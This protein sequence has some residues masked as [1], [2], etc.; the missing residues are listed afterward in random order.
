MLDTIKGINYR[1]GDSEE[2]IQSLLLSAEKERQFY[3]GILGKAP[4]SLRAAQWL[5]GEPAKLEDLKGRPVILHFWN[6]WCGPC[7][8]EIPRL[9]QQYGAAPGN[10]SGPLF[11][12]I[13]A[14]GGPDDLPAIRKFIQEKG[15]TF[16]VMLDA[17]DPENKSWGITCRRYGIYAIPTDATIDADGTLKAVGEH[18]VGK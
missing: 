8:A 9:Q 4:P 6:I 11:I 18:E 1:V 12:A 13:H 15:I 14:G 3:R 7:V 16:P 2:R 5:V 10:Q 17:P